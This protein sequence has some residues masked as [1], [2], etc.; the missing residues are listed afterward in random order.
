MRLSVIVTLALSV[1][2]VIAAPSKRDVTAL[3]KASYIYVATVRKDGTQSK[4]VPVWFIKTRENQVLIDSGSGSWKVKRIRRGSPVLVWI[5]ARTGPAFIG[6]AELVKDRAVEETMI[7]EIPKK[8]LLAWIGFFGPKRARFD[9]G[10]TLTIRITPV[11]DLP[12]GFESRPG[13]PA[14]G[15]DPP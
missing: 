3:A 7:E 11:R 14:P 9:A 1:G 13:T 12:D 4:A 10:K 8:Y 5:D 15:L 6:K 2:V